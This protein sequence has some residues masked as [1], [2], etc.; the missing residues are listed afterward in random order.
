MVNRVCAS[1]TKVNQIKHTR[2]DKMQMRGSS[3][4]KKK[5]IPRSAIMSCS[6][7][8]TRLDVFILETM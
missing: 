7:R 6:L 2:C 1:A 5:K 4:G 8:Q 3:K